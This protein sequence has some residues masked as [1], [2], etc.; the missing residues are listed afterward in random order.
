VLGKT[1]Q[2]LE[3]MKNVKVDSPVRKFVNRASLVMGV[4]WIFLY[5]I[6]FGY[7]GWDVGEPISYLTSVGVDLMALVGFF[8]LEQRLKDEFEISEGRSIGLMNLMAQRRMQRW[9]QCYARRQL[10]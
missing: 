7:Y 2:N 4:N 10:H 9:L 8:D 5:V 6:T 3:V 1:Y